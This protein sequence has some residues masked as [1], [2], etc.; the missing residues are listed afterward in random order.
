MAEAGRAGVEPVGAAG[1]SVDA[2]V[3]LANRLTP[4]ERAQFARDGY[5]VVE[6]AIPESHS[7]QMREILSQIRAE[8]VNAGTL[9]PDEQAKQGA[10]SQAN[11]LQTQEPVLALLTNERVFSK[12]VDILGANIFCY[13]RCHSLT[14]RA[15]TPDAQAANLRIC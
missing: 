14:P 4:I 9:G 8:K 7:A 10:F 3:Y 6:N 2:D 5:F 1:V 12:V 13:V 15:C 11:T